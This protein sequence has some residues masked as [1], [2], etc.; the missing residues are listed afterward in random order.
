MIGGGSQNLQQY[1]VDTLTDSS[2]L[3][4]EGARFRVAPHWSD[5]MIVAR[6]S[7]LVLILPLPSFSVWHGLARVWSSCAR[8]EAQLEESA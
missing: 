6:G 7:P 4:R 8:P 1:Y 5:M 3:A 2:P